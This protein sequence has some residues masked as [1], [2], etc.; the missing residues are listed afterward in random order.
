M[1]TETHRNKQRVG[2][3][4]NIASSSQPIHPG[5]AEPSTAI[6]T[7]RSFQLLFFFFCFSLL[8]GFI[9][10]QIIA[11]LTSRRTT[12]QPFPSAGA[13]WLFSLLLYKAFSK[14]ILSVCVSVLCCCVSN[15]ARIKCTCVAS[16]FGEGWKI[17]QRVD[18]TERHKV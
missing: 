17:I 5:Q 10:R 8:I 16:A 1:N 7:F 3:T 9:W 15:S 12:K 18:G 13:F 4:E 14:K 6:N 2:V 11:C